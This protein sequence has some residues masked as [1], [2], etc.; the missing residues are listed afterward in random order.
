MIN[1][2]L[3]KIRAGGFCEVDIKVEDGRLSVSGTCGR[4]RTVAAA[5]KEAL[6][7]WVRWLAERKAAHGE[8]KK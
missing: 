3:R 1:R 7:Y 6:D 2:K 5:K 8:K 4:V